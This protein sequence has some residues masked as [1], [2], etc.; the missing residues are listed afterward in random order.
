MSTKMSEKTFIRP[1]D[2]RPIGPQV[3]LVTMSTGPEAPVES[4]IPLSTKM[5][6]KVFIHLLNMLRV[7]PQLPLS[8]T[9]TEQEAPVESSRDCVKNRADRL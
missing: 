4:L 8:M 9:S 2:V 1:L 6:E 5:G 3:R 7:D